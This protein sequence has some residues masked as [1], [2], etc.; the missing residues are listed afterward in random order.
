[1]MPEDYELLVAERYTPEELVELLGVSTEE[2]I[3]HF[4]HKLMT[5]DWTEVLGWDPAQR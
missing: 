4:R 1:M 5:L 2:L 3:D